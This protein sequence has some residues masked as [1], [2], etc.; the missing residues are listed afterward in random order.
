MDVVEFF[1]RQ[2]SYAK[3][4]DNKLAFKQQYGKLEERMI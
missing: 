4:C 1:S 3:G 2:S